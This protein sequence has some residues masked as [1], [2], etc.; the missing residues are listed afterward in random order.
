MKDF[1]KIL[2]TLHQWQLQDRSAVMVT[3]VRVAG[4]TYRRPGARMLIA[5][6]GEMVGTVSGGCLEA[7]I[8][9][10]AQSVLEN[11]QPALLTYDTMSDDNTVWGLG[12][13]CN[14]IMEVRL[15]PISHLCNEWDYLAFFQSIQ[16][17]YQPGYFLTLLS[18]EGECPFALGAHLALYPDGRAVGQLSTPEILQWIKQPLSIPGN[19]TYRHLEYKGSKFRAEL[20]LERMEP[21][22]ELVLFGAGQDAE[23]VVELARFLGW[24]VVVVDHRPLYARKERFPEGT[25][26]FLEDYSAFLTNRPI[27]PENPVIVMTHHFLHDLSILKYLV[28]Q[29]PVY[30]GVLGP[31]RRTQQLLQQL[32]IDREWHPQFPERLFSPVGLDIG[33]ESPEE[34]ALAI[35]SEIQAVLS[36]RKGSSLKFRKGPIHLS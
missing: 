6:D 9:T 34:I 35:V 27:Q 2:Q 21:P 32:K 7:D 31:R 12:T 1:Q 10:H 30:V 26:V 15:E 13:G 18:A 20:L 33:S 28:Q 8:A 11:N 29:P 25:Q 19:K 3:V 22:P 24:R 36:G 16:S 4:S 5:G 14:G 23:P 17:G